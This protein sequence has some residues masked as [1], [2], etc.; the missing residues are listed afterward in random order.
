MSALSPT[1]LILPLE[2]KTP[3]YPP[4][5]PQQLNLKSIDPLSNQTFEQNFYACQQGFIPY[6]PISIVESVSLNKRFFHIYDMIHFLKYVKNKED[7]A[8]NGL[9]TGKQV[10]KVYHFAIKC[11]FFNQD[12]YWKLVNLDDSK[13]SLK[14]FE[15]K[16]TEIKNPQLIGI[17]FDSLNFYNSDGENAEKHQHLRKAQYVVAQQINKGALFPQLSDTERELEELRW[18]RCSAHGSYEGLL[19]YAS[20]SYFSGK[21]T[22]KNIAHLINQSKVSPLYP[23]SPL[24]KTESEAKKKL[25]NLTATLKS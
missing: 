4:E 21:D 6:Y 7:E 10:V 20:K 18:L 13:H 1:S 17:L 9:L 15:I 24:S 23:Q 2:I 11:L 22:E 25:I 19:R 12:Q 8:L 16:F 3:D 14:L 5:F